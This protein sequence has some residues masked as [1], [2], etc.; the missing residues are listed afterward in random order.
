M[1]VFLAELVVDLVVLQQRQLIIAVNVV[2]IMLVVKGLFCQEL[3][4]IVII[5]VVGGDVEVFGQQVNAELQLDF[6]KQAR[7]GKEAKKIIIIIIFEKGIIYII[8]IQIHS[9][10]IKIKSSSSLLF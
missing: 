8:L 6:P 5:V 10:I 1:Q 3:E 7:E 4:K 2:L 9:I